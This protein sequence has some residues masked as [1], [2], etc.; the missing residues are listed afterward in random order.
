L[1]TIWQHLQPADFQ[2]F[3]PTSDRS[4][5]FEGTNDPSSEGHLSAAVIASA[6]ER[7]YHTSRWSDVRNVYRETV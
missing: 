5:E 6:H 1:A 2:Q 3:V 7:T 4:D